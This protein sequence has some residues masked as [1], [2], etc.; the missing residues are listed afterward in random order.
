MECKSWDEIESSLRVEIAKK[1]AAYVEARRRFDTALIPSGIPH[2]DGVLNIRNAGT[3]HTMAVSAYRVALI[4]H[5]DFILRGVVPN[6][7]TLVGP[8]HRL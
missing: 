6:R 1:R 4:E 3:L 7:F 2:P 5:H 8:P